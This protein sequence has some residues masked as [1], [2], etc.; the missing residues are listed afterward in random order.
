MELNIT[1][2]QAQELKKKIESMSPEELKEFQKKQCIFCHIISGRTSSRKIYEDE[3]ALAILDINPANIGHILLLPKEHYSILPQIPEDIVDHLFMVAKA[4]S[5]TA[6]RALQ[7]QGTNIFVA[8]GVAAGQKAQHFMMHIIPRSDNDNIGLELA[9]NEFNK[10]DIE[11]VRKRLILSI[12]KTLGEVKEKESKKKEEKITPNVMEAEFK[13]IPK[14][15]TIE[16]ETISKKPIK[17]IKKKK[18][19]TKRR[20][21]K[22]RES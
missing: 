7:C 3:H 10:T 14:A 2:E 4:L 20:E 9:E 12:S 22:G 21:D 17:K 1:P 8:N 19:R 15:E 18:K 5:H 11:T 13:E 6:L 16:K